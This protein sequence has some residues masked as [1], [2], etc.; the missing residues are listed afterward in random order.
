MLL[1]KRIK[2]IR[3]SKG[4]TQ[5][6]MADNLGI[7]QPAYSH[8]EHEAANCTFA[9]IIKISEILGVSIPFLTDI[10]SEI[11]EEDL[12]LMSMKYKTKLV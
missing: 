8:Y 5:K 10:Y 1:A 2:E 9:T 12:W 6:Y 3:K 7:S 11:Y 4:L